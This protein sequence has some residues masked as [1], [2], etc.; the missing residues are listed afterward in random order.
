MSL[1]IRTILVL[2]CA[3]VIVVLSFGI[4]KSIELEKSRKRLNMLET[5][6]TVSEFHWLD[7]LKLF[8]P[9]FYNFINNKASMQEIIG[10][11]T[12]VFLYRFSKFTC[13]SCLFE[14]LH[15][16]D[17]FQQ[18]IGRNKILLLPTYPDNREGS[19]ELNN[20][21]AKFNFVNI[22]L[23][24]FILPFRENDVIQRYFAVIDRDGN[25]TMVFFPRRGETHLTRLYFSEVK[26]I[27]EN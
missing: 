3:L 1:K 9:I 25:L 27:I 11:R 26:K 7:N 17:Q 4:L 10:N 20:V 14:D 16:I 12:S 15:E 23:D 22:A 18:E 13:E 24:S 8:S 6:L 19:I 21:L 2:L 5:E